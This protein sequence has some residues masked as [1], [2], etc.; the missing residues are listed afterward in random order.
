VN[1]CEVRLDPRE[2]DLYAWVDP[3]SAAGMLRWESSKRALAAAHRIKSSG[4]SR[5]GSGC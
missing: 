5:S 4:P 1:K 3:E 2:H